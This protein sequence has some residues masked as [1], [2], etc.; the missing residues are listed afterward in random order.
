MISRR[1]LRGA[2]PGHERMRCNYRLS[3]GSRL[4]PMSHQGIQRIGRRTVALAIGF[5]AQRRADGEAE[6][7]QG[8]AHHLRREFP[9]GVCVAVPGAG[10]QPRNRPLC[11]LSCPL[12]PRPARSEEMAARADARL[13]QSRAE[14]AGTGCADR[15]P[16]AHGRAQARAVSVIGDPRPCPAPPR[17]TDLREFHR[18]AD[19]HRATR[20]ATSTS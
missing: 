16:A 9:A 14:R 8:L 6:D 12:H 11:L 10:D 13:H 15:I 4:L 5:A 20:I 3:R 19:P 18:L 1:H 7:T 2:A 17:Q